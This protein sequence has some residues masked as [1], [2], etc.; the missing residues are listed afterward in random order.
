M[1]ANKS[2]TFPT[3]LFLHTVLR[4]RN[5]GQLPEMD[6]RTGH[7]FSSLKFDFRSGGFLSAEEFPTKLFLCQGCGKMETTGKEV[8]HSRHE[9]RNYLHLLN[10]QARH[11]TTK[12]LFLDE[13]RFK[14]FLLLLA[15]DLSSRIIIAWDQALQWGEKGKKRGRIEKIS[16]SE[17]S[18]AVQ[19]GRGKGHPFPS[20]DYLSGSLRSQIVSFAHADFFSFF[21]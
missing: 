21:P 16:A 2:F 3:S 8:D 11:V 9:N 13:T 5:N 20:P 6:M 18:P 10:F 4:P 14:V 7:P 15:P 19:L 12:P 17:A 1:N